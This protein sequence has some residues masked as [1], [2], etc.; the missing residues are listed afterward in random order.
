[1][2][3]P[4]KK[5]YE[6][7]RQRHQFADKSL[8]SQSYCLSS[9]HEWIWELDHKEDCGLKN[10][11]FWA[12]VLE[13][14]LESPLDRKIK[15]FNPK[16]NQPWLF[17]GCTGAEAEALIL[18]PPDAK[19]WLI[20]KDPHAGKDWRQEEKEVTED[21]IDRC[22]TNSMDMSLKKFWQMVKDQEAWS[23]AVHGVSESQIWLNNW[24]ATLD[25]ILIFL[26]INLMASLF[27]IFIYFFI[28]CDFRF[29]FL[30]NSKF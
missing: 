18:W 21:E 13:K 25:K 12:V 8:I 6:K 27:W 3:S 15:P 16:G 10:W 5:C 30:S 29:D 24:T 20:G 19:S 2:L 9:R 22:I 28:V 14:T 17:I 23:A 1:M 4:W 26:K 11:C 7:P